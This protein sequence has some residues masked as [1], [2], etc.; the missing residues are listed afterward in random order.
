LSL[1]RHGQQYLCAQ[2]GVEP[3]QCPLGSVT[4]NNNNSDNNATSA[5]VFEWKQ[6]PQHSYNVDESLQQG[7]CEVCHGLQQCWSSAIFKL[8]R[9]R[10]ALL[11]KRLKATAPLAT[12]A[13]A[14]PTAPTR[15]NP[16]LPERKSC[17]AAIYRTSSSE[18][19]SMYCR[20]TVTSL[21]TTTT[22]TTT[23]ST[24]AVLHEET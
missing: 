4:N 7:H 12:A 16:S 17:A 3:C 1:N 20:R 8:V 11:E 15:M 21:S 24:G 22:T 2:H 9:A 13:A 10:P 19:D 23:L 18:K 6:Q 14:A 5:P